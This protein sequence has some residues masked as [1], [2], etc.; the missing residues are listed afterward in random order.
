VKRGIFIV[1][2]ARIIYNPT[3]GRNLVTKKLVNILEKL[4][5]AGYE[6]SC[7]ATEGPGSAAAESTKAAKNGVDVVI[8]AGGD[9]TLS[10]VV[11]GLMQVTERPKLG[12]LPC[13]TSNDF[14][15]ALKIPVNIEKAVDVIINGQSK[16]IDIG[17]SG[18]RYF[19]NVAAIG[20][21]TEVSDATSNLKTFVGPLAYYMK[22]IENLAKI[23][24]PFTATIATPEQTFN[25]IEI[26]LLIIANSITVGGFSCITPKADISDGLLDLLIIPKNS[27]TNLLQVAALARKGEHIYDD[28]IHYLQTTCVNV[29]VPRA[30]KFNLDGEWSALSST[31]FAVVPHCLNIFVPNKPVFKKIGPKLMRKVPRDA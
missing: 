29:S 17:C 2:R 30:F 25:N 11:N 7:K 12:L 24:R 18:N 23:T 22:V 13:G 1:Q 19:L 5:R 27:I 6:T 4:E 8:A 9:G 3:A 10:E 15:R 14:A 28:R 20:H 16:L 31:S 21:L 26:V